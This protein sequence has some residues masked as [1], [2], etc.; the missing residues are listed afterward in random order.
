MQQLIDALRAAGVPEKDIQ[1][2]QISLYPDY[3]DSGDLRGYEA[4][5]SVTVCVS[6]EKAGA[7]LQAAVGAGANQVDGPTLTKADSDKLYAD[8]LRAAVADARA[9][10]EVLAAAAGVKVGEVV[11]IVEGSTSSGP[12]AYDMAASPEAPIQPGTQDI[13]ASVTVSFAIV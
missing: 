11:S 4:T 3:S 12:I 10:A 9:R 2:S 13:E 6:L 7:A 8:A 5:N 1:T